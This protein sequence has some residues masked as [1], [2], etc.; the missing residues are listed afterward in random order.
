MRNLITLLVIFAVVGLGLW[1]A[2]LNPDPATLRLPGL[3][4]LE[5]RL[6]VV[7]FLSLLAGVFV[8]L[9][10]S[11]VLSSRDA[12]LRWRSR[13]QQQHAA[14]TEGIFQEGLRAALRG[15]PR[16][17]LER[18]ETVVERDPHHLEGW[19][20]GGDA[21]REAGELDRA[22]DLHL[23]ARG[24][25]PSDPR[26]QEALAA[27]FE[28]LGEYSRAIKYLQQRIEADPKGDPGVYAK[29][30]DLL[31]RLG[32]WDEAQEAQEKRLKLV[33]SPELRSEEE[34]ILRGLRLERGRRLL[35]EGHH[36]EAAAIFASLVKADPTFVPAHL[37][38]GETHLAA[39]D[40]ARAVQAWQ[41][42]FEVTHSV[43]LL[44]RRV[45]HHIEHEEP[46][47]A[48]QTYRRA[49]GELAPQEALAARLRLAQLLFR[50]E[51]LEEAK[52][53]FEALE[54]RSEFSPT[55]HYE[56]AKLRQRLG[57]DRGAARMFQEI[58][59]SAGLLRMVHR[60]G[61]CQAVY[62]S[63]QLRCAECGRWGTVS[64]DVSEELRLARER[65][66][67]A[68]RV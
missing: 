68:P 16:E 15:K 9:L 46:E 62:D 17:A 67:H 32:R 58:I 33:K 64:M 34:A 65:T 6:W 22:V 20:Q 30:R 61:R 54:E 2:W 8:A 29:L 42:G 59:D 7:A 57:D 48:I 13:R 35:G 38:L 25:A 14:E 37:L 50:L 23:R 10:Y 31:A 4:P 63:Y 28:A 24:L 3:R 47:A 52:A 21:A 27:D 12:L 43:V 40:A 26:V 11:A 19:L 36:D 60:C 45:D 18:L 1:V 39:G 56:L 41:D 44:E 49:T 51:M 55:L 66:V 53:E 5:T